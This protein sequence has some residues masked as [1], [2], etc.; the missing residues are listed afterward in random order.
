MMYVSVGF[1]ISFSICGLLSLFNPMFMS[2]VKYEIFL[3]FA[4]ILMELFAF[5]L[6]NLKS[7]LHI[8]DTGLFIGYMFYKYF[9]L[10]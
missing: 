2:F 7:S 3:A 9:P 1:W 8:L 6:L 10:V 4:H 5:L